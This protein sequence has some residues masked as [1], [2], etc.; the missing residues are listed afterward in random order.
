MPATR[1]SWHP[2]AHRV[3][4]WLGSGEVGTADGIGAEASFH[5]PSGLSVAG[6]RLYIADT[7][8]HAVRVAEI[9]T[10]EVRTLEISGL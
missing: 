8:N 1:R 4:S 9:E 5:K 6:G 7:N 10:G 2:D 3:W